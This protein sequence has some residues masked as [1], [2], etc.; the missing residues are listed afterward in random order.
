MGDGGRTQSG[1]IYLPLV[2]V[3]DQRLELEL[4]HIRQVDRFRVRGTLDGRSASL[5]RPTLQRKLGAE[6]E[7]ILGQEVP[8]NTEKAA[9][10]LRD[11]N[12]HVPRG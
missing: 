5:V 6:D 10:D 3:P 7:G 4:R 12:P 9:L 11:E 2:K 8:V 1:G